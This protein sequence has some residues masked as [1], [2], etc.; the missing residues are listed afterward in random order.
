M[1]KLTPI[2]NQEK[3]YVQKLHERTGWPIKIKARGFTAYLVGK[4]P[5]TEGRSCPIYRFPG[6]NSLVDECEMIPAE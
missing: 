2:M 4:Q 5:L 1:I 3:S 6:G